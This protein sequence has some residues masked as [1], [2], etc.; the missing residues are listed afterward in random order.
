MS[1]PQSLMI[2][3]HG[4][5][6][7]VGMRP[8]LYKTANAFQLTGFVKN[9]GASVVIV[10]SG[11]PEAMDGFLNELTN[12]SPPNAVL[13]HIDISFHPKLH[14]QDFKILHSAEDEKIQGC[15]LPDLA[16]CQDCLDDILNH[17]DRR[18][19][20]AFTNCTNCG[21]RYSIIKDLPYD[22]RNTTMGT[23]TMCED[24]NEEY[25]NPEN[26]RFHAQPNACPVCG[27][28]YIL[29]HG[30]GEQIEWENPIEMGKQLL[31]DGKILAI[32]GIGGYHLVCNAEN[33]T[34]VATLRRRKNRPHKPFAMMTC[35][36]EDAM[37]ICFVNP[38][39][40]ETISNNKRPIV[41][42]KK[43]PTTF[44]PDNIA[45]KLSHYGVMLPY[46]PLH[47]LLFDENLKYL[48]MT[49]GNIS[50][51]PIC[52]KDEDALEKLSDV[53][54][55]FL[56]HNR[57]IMTPIDDSVVKVINDDVLLS[58]CGRGYAPVAL[59]LNAPNELLAVGGNQ[60]ASLCFVHNQLAHISQYMGELHYL[61]AC[62]EYTLV[63]D[64]LSRL[65]KA[66]PQAI[67]HDLHPNYFSTQYAKRQEIT[68]IAVQHHHAHMVAC[69]AENNFYDEGIGIIFDGTGMGEDGAIWGG[70]FFIGSRSQFKRVGHLEYV[71]LQGGDSAIEEPWKCA[72]SY[73][74][75]IHESIEP[76][77]PNLDKVQVQVVEKALE[78]KVNCYQSSSMGRLFDCVAAVLLG[79][80]RI[81]YEAQA[82][83]ELESLVDSSIT[84]TYRFTISERAGTFIL[85]YQS[86]LES[87]LEDLR[88]HEPIS[89][90]SSK[91]HNTISKAT[92]DCACRIREEYLL[93]NV[94]LGG[95][96]FENTYLLK[97]VITGLKE[98]DF[99]VFYN[100][101]VPLNDGGLSFGQAAVA[102]S[103]LEERAYVSGSS[104][105]NYFG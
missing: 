52:Y 70:E 64:R 68:T 13:H 95:G 10:L 8:F 40:K 55:Y 97:K 67:A 32:K 1:E 45:P 85:G 5:V 84:G 25:E 22:R 94:F 86:I 77:F 75:A 60:K 20:Y 100:Q 66:A 96:V 102:A 16:I 91:F 21:P 27:P 33:E 53:A 58:R 63:L 2:Q 81:S 3:I 54:D 69:M 51:M 71:T 89:V 59:P 31:K 92:I 34:A 7:G 103:I 74:D 46:T 57:E 4:I 44:L 101:K 98:M 48:I 82:A 11:E 56:I 12:N 105:K 90:I 15:L 61:E 72:L 49:S 23:F 87:V 17:H 79:C 36:L 78:K 76:F 19:A 47:Y 39:E 35:K 62:K 88:K 43:D 99:Q 104:D 50:G 37:K 93:D 83:I 18:F 73:F 41:L 30:N 26:R 14:F 42:L 29:L 6:Q 80:S 28:R 65:L 24:C 38:K 9:K